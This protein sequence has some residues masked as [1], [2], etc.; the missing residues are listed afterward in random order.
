MVF[1]DF[2][3]KFHKQVTN[4]S[5]HFVVIVLWGILMTSPLSY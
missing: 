2:L 4:V 1:C 3:H 5:Q